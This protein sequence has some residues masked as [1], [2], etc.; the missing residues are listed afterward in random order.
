MRLLPSFCKCV[1]QPGT[2]LMMILDFGIVGYSLR[3]SNGQRVASALAPHSSELAVEVAAAPQLPT[4]VAE[5]SAA[6]SAG[7]GA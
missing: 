4:A 7:E 6:V 5:R 3:R 1:P 2:W